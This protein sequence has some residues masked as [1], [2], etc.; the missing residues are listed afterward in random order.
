MND[1]I[2]CTYIGHATCIIQIGEA[3]ILT[4]PNF[5]RRVLTQKRLSELSINPAE[6]PEFD[7][8]LV[9][10]AHLDHL[11]TSSYKYLS[12]HTP[13]IVPE[14]SERP[15]GKFTPNPIIELSH[16]SSHE[17]VN[18]V[19]ITAVPAAHASYHFLPTNSAKANAYLIR[20]PDVDGAVLFCGD[21]AYG[22]H[23]GQIGNLGKISLAILP[24]GAY[25]PRWFMSK[26]HMTPAEAVQAFEDMKAEHMVPIH[27]GTFRLSL[28]QPNAPLEWLEKILEERPDLNKR[29]HAL[30]PGEKFDAPAG[31][32]N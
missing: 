2:S 25:E 14:R 20:H 30:K 15:I 22:E 21:S 8:I 5:S 24:I 11:D 7:A 29:I 6:L 27:Y 17:L 19:E 23:F 18:G 13:I 28:E 1:K 4:D 10:H 16:Y 32:L 26:R 9:S 31:N 12:C 3:K